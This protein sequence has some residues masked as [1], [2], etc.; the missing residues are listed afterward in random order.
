M[1]EG[2]KLINVSITGPKPSRFLA[3]LH[4]TQRMA[5]SSSLDAVGIRL[6][7]LS[8]AQSLRESLNMRTTVDSSHEKG[9]FQEH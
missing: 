1:S 4:F 3:C 2:E 7:P 6:I 9:T 5:D 8:L